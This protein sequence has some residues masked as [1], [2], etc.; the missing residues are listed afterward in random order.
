[1]VYTSWSRSL[2]LLEILVHMTGF[3]NLP[4]DRYLITLDIPDNVQISEVRK[5]DLPESWDA[6]PP[7]RI[8]QIIGDDFVSTNRTAVLKV[9]SSIIPGEFNY[10]INPAHQEASKIKIV[11]KA[12]FPMD[13]R[14]FE[15]I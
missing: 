7:V 8:T 5:E 9:P 1:M 14:L 2:A 6:I 15:K 11:H 4:S 3:P 12:K 13:S 10:L